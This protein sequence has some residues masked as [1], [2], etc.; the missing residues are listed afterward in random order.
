MEKHQNLNFSG[1]CKRK[2]QNKLTA[3][4]FKANLIQEQA[5]ATE[6]LI[7]TLMETHTRQ[8][9]TLIKST[10]NAMK[11]MM[12]PIKD[13]N[14]PSYSNNQRN[15]EKKKNDTPICKHCNKKH[16]SKAKDECWEL[17]K[18]KDSHPSTWKSIKST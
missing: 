7:A 15:E 8:M 17:D 2:K 12:L 9:E 14:N 11:E 18:N 1:I 3:K 5:E 10:T 4:H 13:N 16:P 6:E